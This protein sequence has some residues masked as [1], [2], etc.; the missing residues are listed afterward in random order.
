MLVYMAFQPGSSMFAPLSGKTGTEGSL[1]AASSPLHTFTH[2][3]EFP[4]NTGDLTLLPPTPQGGPSHQGLV[5]CPD[6]YS[7]P[8]QLKRYHKH[9]CY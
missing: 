1:Q 5:Q 6:S 4:S 2:P 8:N 7:C 9:S 3:E